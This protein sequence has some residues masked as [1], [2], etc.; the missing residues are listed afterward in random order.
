MSAALATPGPPA[1]T[2]TPATTAEAPVQ[3]TH[4]VVAS[5]EATPLSTIDPGELREVFG[6]FPQ[7]VVVVAAAVDGRPEGLVASTF[8]VG[9]SLEPPLATL[10]VQHSSSTWPKLVGA[11]AELGISLIGR[12][13]EALCRKI[14]SKDRQSRFSGVDLTT[15]ARGAITLDGAPVTFT[16]RIH[17]QVRAGDH[18]IIV[19]ELLDLAVEEDAEALV[20]HQSRFRTLDPLSSE[21]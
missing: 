10:A 5:R 20:F 17:D 21:S 19:L 6:R 2:P 7:S 13:Q 18:D 14:A 9:V 1:T 11:D 4:D 16:T 12:G 8:T 3:K 15:G